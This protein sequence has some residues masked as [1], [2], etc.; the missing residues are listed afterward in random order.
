M[1]DHVGKTIWFTGLSGSGKTTLSSMLKAVLE[2]RGVPVVLLDGDLLRSGLNRDLGFSALDRAE[3][4]RRS[5]ETAKILSEAGHTVIAA[6]ITPLETLRR[7]LRGIFPADRFVEI[8]LDC[9]LNVCEDRDPKGLYRRARRGE[10]PEFTGVSSP[11]EPPVSPDFVAST[12]RLTPEDCVNSILEFLEGRFGD[13]CRGTLAVKPSPSRKRVAVIGLDCVPPSL[14]FGDAAIDL[15]NLRRL[16]HHGVWGH[17]RSTDPPITIPAWTTM[18]TGKDPGELGLYGFRNRLSHSYDRMITVNSGHVNEP[19]VWDYVEATGRS[20][21]LVGIPQTYPPVPHNGITIAGFPAPDESSPFTYPAWLWDELGTGRE[22]Y[23]I[24]AKGF[25]TDDKDRLLKDLYS[26]VETRFRVAADLIVRNPWDFF[27]LVEI[28]T[29]RLHHGF[30]R[31]FS[32]THRLY[33]PGNPYEKVATEFYQFLDK[34]IGSLLAVM[35]DD[36]TVMVV[37]DH[38][39]RDMVGGVAI[40]EW[41]IQNG[42]LFLKEQP[43]EETE[44]RPETIDWTKTVAWSEGGYYARIF[45]NVQ[46]REPKGIIDPNDYESVRDELADRLGTMPDGEGTM[47]E[48]QVLK[49]DRI[50]RTCRNAPPDL[51]V[52]FDGL[53]RRSVGTVGKGEIIRSGNDTGPDDANHDPEGIFIAALLSDVRQGVRKDRRVENVSCMDITP[54]VLHRFGLP[55][56]SGV[57][58]QIVHLDNP[59]CEIPETASRPGEVEQRR[60]TSGVPQGFTA[61]EEEIVKKRL[62]DLGYI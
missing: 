49:P 17:L 51:M 55:V 53:S 46:G 50:Y 22:R 19:R 28:A 59:A 60:E 44:L 6:F 26:M 8:Y 39:A 12:G 54:T 33:R 38:G 3:N 36:T 34:C 45:L 37:S 35:T 43:A 31:Y 58:G 27:M 2:R 41:L 7:A 4:I 29:D 40:N 24:D 16:M 23:L 1:T 9:P 18:T 52:Y 48:N 25:R 13:L 10:I 30:W 57:G 62:M 47:M 32:P 61:E 11:F 56:P 5:G 20:S 14:V 15:P 21:I 42:F